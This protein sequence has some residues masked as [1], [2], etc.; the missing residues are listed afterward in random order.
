MASQD[1]LR[2]YNLLKQYSL[3]V[4]IEEGFI[5]AQNGE[6]TLH[7]RHSKINNR[8]DVGYFAL[9]RMI[10]ERTLKDGPKIIKNWYK[11]L[12]TLGS[13]RAYNPVLKMMDNYEQVPSFKVA[14]N[15]EGVIELC[16]YLAVKMITNA[17]EEKIIN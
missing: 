7:V 10:A 13:T 16:S 15:L 5:F 4:S 2:L 17:R 3:E 8:F 11:Q 14:L 12:R 1:Y 6:E 9:D